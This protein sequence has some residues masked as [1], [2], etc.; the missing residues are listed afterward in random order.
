M[1]ECNWFVDHGGTQE[2]WP[3]VT[4]FPRTT[5]R[6]YRLYRLLTDLE[7]LLSHTLD[8]QQR[9][10]AIYPLVRCFLADS[11]WLQYFPIAPNPDTGWAV[12]ILYDEPDFPLTVQLV[13][14]HPQQVS[15]I[16]NHGCWGLV[17]LLRGQEEN[18]FWGRS[19]ADPNQLVTAGRQVLDAGD[20]IGFMP[21]TIHQVEALGNEPTVSFNIYGET[22][23]DQRFE[24]DLTN[25]TATNF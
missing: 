5:P 1:T 16:H 8:D 4:H 22:D 11:A 7:D 25:G 17:A 2:L 14:W 3:T 23:Y 19:P 6:P 21:D 20:L 18:R 10:E 24:F 13:A 9:L 15:P 12:E